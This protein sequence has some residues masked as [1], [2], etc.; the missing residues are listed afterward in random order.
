MLKVAVGPDLH[1]PVVNK[2]KS[3]LRDVATLPILRTCDS[4]T[5]GCN[6]RGIQGGSCATNIGLLW[7]YLEVVRTVQG[8]HL[9]HSNLGV[10]DTAL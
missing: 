9:G 10:G 4:V 8:W 1:L 6:L 3:P 2:G 5:F 7:Q